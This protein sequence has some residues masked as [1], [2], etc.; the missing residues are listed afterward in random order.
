MTYQEIINHAKDM[1]EARVE[2]IDD[3]TWTDDMFVQWLKEALDDFLLKVDSSLLEFL[4]TTSQTITSADTKVLFEIKST[5]LKMQSESFGVNSK[6]LLA[7]NF[8][9]PI[10]SF[11]EKLTVSLY[12]TSIGRG[13]IIVQIQGDKNNLP[14]EVLGR[15]EE[16]GEVVSVGWRNFVFNRVFIPQGTMWIVVTSNS[17]SADWSIGYSNMVG[18]SRISGNGGVSWDTLPSSF[19]FAVK[20]E[21]SNII[22]N[23]FLKL[24]RVVRDG[25]E[26]YIT[27]I[28]EID[29]FSKAT[30]N[31]PIAYLKGRELI[32]KPAGNVPVE[33]IYIRRPGIK[34]WEE[35]ILPPAWHS[36]LGYFICA[37]ALWKDKNQ[38]G[39]RYMLL[40]NTAIENINNKGK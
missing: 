17:D 12:L 36:I 4:Y 15:V 29:S 5:T 31:Y 16:K 24:L 33:V 19:V 23:D 21:K 40:F 39:D 3:I 6:L 38:E 1:I 34:L 28:Q 32:V 35:C 18:N 25:K 37:K 13:E 8:S 10:K 9:S 14:D 26:C 11:I 2:G 22:D 20:G 30:K 7:Q 27:N